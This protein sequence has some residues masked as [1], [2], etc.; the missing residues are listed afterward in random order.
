MSL[1]RLAILI[2]GGSM[3]VAVGRH[4]ADRDWWWAMAD[5]IA[6]VFF[7]W[8]YVW[9]EEREMRRGHRTTAANCKWFIGDNG[10]VDWGTCIP[11]EEAKRDVDAR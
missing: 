5:V 11:C 6:I 2:A 10:W 8:L 9:V 3:V 7:I 1:Q 4:V